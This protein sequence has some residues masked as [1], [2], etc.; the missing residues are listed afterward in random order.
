VKSCCEHATIGV[1]QD[2]C[3][4]PQQPRTAEEEQAFALGVRRELSRLF[5]HP[6]TTVLM[7][8]RRLP[9]ADEHSRLH[10]Y[11][12]RGW[13]HIE[14]SLSSLVKSRDC[15]WSLSRLQGAADWASF[16]EE[17]RATRL[18]PLSP[19]E[20]ASMVQAKAASGELAFGVPSDLSLVTELYEYGFVRAFDT[21]TS[22]MNSARFAERPSS[23]IVYMDGDSFGWDDEA[24]FRVARALQYAKE[25]CSFAGGPLTV[26]F[27]GFQISRTARAAIV[28]SVFGIT[29]LEA[30]ALWNRP[31]ER[32][33]SSPGRRSA[34]HRL[35][36]ALRALVQPQPRDPPA[37]PT[38]P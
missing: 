15:L 21:Y 32:P 33:S 27:N 19:V 28:D 29:G 10:P 8:D 11:K 31:A 1:F 12:T 16:R 9:E 36:R 3:S 38:E 17:L 14:T 37:R 18:P 22:V 20:V 5:A 24:A 30:L 34:C 25:H 2:Y 7:L 35:C 4:Y 13:C 6:Y 23:H 26:V